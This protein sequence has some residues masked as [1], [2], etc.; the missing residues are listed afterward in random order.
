MSYTIINFRP[1]WTDLSS[2]E[3]IKKKPILDIT[4][5]HGLGSGIYGIIDTKDESYK[6]KSLT[7]P[8]EIQTSIPIDNPLILNTNNK[9]S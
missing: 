1:K 5:T 8:H 9:I 4:K 6:Q 2:S 3:Y 7:R